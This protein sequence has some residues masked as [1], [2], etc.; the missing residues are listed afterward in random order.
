MSVLLQFTTEATIALITREERRRAL[1]QRQ[2]RLRNARSAPTILQNSLVG[3]HGSNGVVERVIQEV[4]GLVRWLEVTIR[5]AT[6]VL[7]GPSHPT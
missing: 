3:S 4:T 2:G 7:L 1:L 6:N 5:T